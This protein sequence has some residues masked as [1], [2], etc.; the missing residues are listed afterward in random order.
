MF[1][2]VL[3]LDVFGD[4][5][6]PTDAELGGSAPPSREVLVAFGAKRGQKENSNGEKA[7]L[8]LGFILLWVKKN[9]KKTVFGYFCFFY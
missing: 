9:E 8:C 6:D 1:S 3:F 4:G 5:V 2:E 7:S